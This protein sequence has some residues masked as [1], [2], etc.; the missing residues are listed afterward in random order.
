VLVFATGYVSL[1]SVAAAA[2][3]PVLVYLFNA[4]GP[5]FWL[6][7]LLA[8]FVIFAHRANIRRLL[9]G[10]EHRFGRKARAS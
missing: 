1:A 10:E 8:T 2:V 6:S 7:L 9:R 4:T 3:M 5:V